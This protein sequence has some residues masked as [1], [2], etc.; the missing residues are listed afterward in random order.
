MAKWDAALFGVT[1]TCGVG[2]MMFGLSA[3]LQLEDLGCNER[4]LVVT[5][6]G[7]RV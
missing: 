1:R 7:E 4:D 6:E 3:C 5:R 2:Q